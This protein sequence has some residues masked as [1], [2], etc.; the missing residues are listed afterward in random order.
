MVRVRDAARYPDHRPAEVYGSASELITDGVDGLLFT[1]R[2][3]RDLARQ[4][5]AQADDP[6]RPARVAEAP[7]DERADEVGRRHPDE[8]AVVVGELFDRGLAAILLG[9]LGVI[10]ALLLE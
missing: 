7:H 2:D 3:A 9:D 1:A 4:R 6:V 5:R 8:R 10:G